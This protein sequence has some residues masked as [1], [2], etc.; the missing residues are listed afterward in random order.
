[1]SNLSNGAPRIY[2]PMDSLNPVFGGELRRDT[3]IVTSFQ[4]I[5]MGCSRL[6]STFSGE[7]QI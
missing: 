3:D 5:L 1:M 4:Q 2:D 7:S 6:L